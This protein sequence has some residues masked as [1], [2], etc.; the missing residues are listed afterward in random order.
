ML[1]PT[2]TFCKIAYCLKYPSLWRLGSAVFLRLKIQ[3]PTGHRVP[4]PQCEPAVVEEGGFSHSN[5]AA[6]EQTTEG[7][8]V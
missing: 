7:E 2:A 4:Q 8:Q 1:R 5:C 6:V 3:A